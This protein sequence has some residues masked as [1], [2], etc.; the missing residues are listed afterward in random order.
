MH[1]RTEDWTYNL[2][3][4]PD[5]EPNL[6]P[7]GVR[8]QHYNQLSQPAVAD[9]IFY[10]SFLDISNDLY[11]ILLAQYSWFTLGYENASWVML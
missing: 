1:V 3:L 10:L 11:F 9:L 2:R 7:F 4:Y 8:E 6:K 5:W